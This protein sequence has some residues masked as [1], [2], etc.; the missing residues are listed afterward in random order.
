MLL[1]GSMR[2]SRRRI[3]TVTSY[4]FFVVFAYLTALR[5]PKVLSQNIDADSDLCVYAVSE[6]KTLRVEVERLKDGKKLNPLLQPETD[7]VSVPQGGFCWGIHAFQDKVYVA[8]T[9]MSYVV[10]FDPSGDP[11]KFANETTNGWDPVEYG[12]VPDKRFRLMMKGNETRRPWDVAFHGDSPFAAMTMDL[13]AEEIAVALYPLDS[14]STSSQ[15]RIQTFDTPE[16][17]AFWSGITYVD[18]TTV[19]L[20]APTSPVVK[21]DLTTGQVH[22]FAPF[23]PGVYWG[24]TYDPTTDLVYIACKGLC[25]RVVDRTGKEIKRLEETGSGFSTRGLAVSESKLIVTGTGFDLRVYDKT[26]LQFERTMCKN[27]V[28]TPA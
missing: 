11:G 3:C 24:V 9:S 2:P 10:E 21:L 5:T 14:T 22:E 26:T 19:L 27:H 6:V 23:E 28:L 7:Y 17:R 18:A 20:A 13:G 8:C 4:S 15:S 12:S 1:L 16:H 25:V